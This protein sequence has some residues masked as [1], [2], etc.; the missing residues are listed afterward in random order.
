MELQKLVFVRLLLLTLITTQVLA[1]CTCEQEEDQGKKSEALRYKLIALASILIF[2]G[3]GVCLPF[4]GKIFPSLSPEKDGFFVIKAFA[5]GV[6]LATGFIH[7]LPDAFESL[8]HPCLN[9]HPWQDFS[10]TGFIAMVATILT[11]LFETS[12]A[13][14]QH[15]IQSKSRPEKD[16]D[17]ENDRPRLVGQVAAHTH[18][19]HG[20]AHGSMMLVDGGDSGLSLVDRYRIV[21][22]VNQ[23]MKKRISSL[24]RVLCVYLFHPNFIFTLRSNTLRVLYCKRYRLRTGIR[25]EVETEYLVYKD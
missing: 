2:G 8:T 4:M 13:A 21:S 14:Y 9:K 23:F 22:K 24:W 16:G 1:E 3:I 12:S 6:I 5:A 11:L 25:L 19:S 17:E 18:A 15:R 20:H 7:V 10:F